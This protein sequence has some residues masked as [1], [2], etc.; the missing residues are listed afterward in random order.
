MFKSKGLGLIVLACFLNMGFLAK[1]NA[2]SLH[3]KISAKARTIYYVNSKTGNDE[4]SGT[5]KASAWKSLEKVNSMIFKPGDKILFR[6]G[7]NY[8]GQ[9]VMHGSGN[10]G[11]LIVISK[12]GKGKLP[13][14]EGK[15]D[16]LETVFLK[17]VQYLDVQNLEISNKGTI[18]KARRAGVRLVVDNFGTAHHIHLTHLFVHDVNGSNVKSKGGGTGITWSCRGDSIKS[19]FDD[20]LI[21]HNHLVRTDRNGITGSSRFDSRSNWFPSLHVVIRNNLLED[22]G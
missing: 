6:A 20:L 2:R 22:I 9:L 16:Y 7:T 21:A 13:H 19:R 11:D 10:A 3:Q 15:G 17:N 14:I 18:R 1:G 8:V 12:Y 5:S 4:N